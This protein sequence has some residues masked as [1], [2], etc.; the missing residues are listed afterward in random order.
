[1]SKRRLE[2]IGLAFVVLLAVLV[3]G[4]GDSEGAQ[5]ATSG[6]VEVI[7]SADFDVADYAGQPFVM[8]FF[9]SWCGPCNS[10]APA[11]AEFAAANSDVRFVGI[12]VGDEEADATAFMKQYGLDYP[13]VM[14]DGS[15]GTA[16]NVAGVPT[17]IFF[18]SDGREADRIIGAAGAE[19]FEQSLAKAR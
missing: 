19:Q 11:L 16:W 14:D 18:S 9:G 8:N 1:M 4:C 13:I 12:A 5:P 2:L 17:T 7:P 3:M 10:E 15:L 6:D